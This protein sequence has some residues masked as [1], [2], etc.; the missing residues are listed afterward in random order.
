MTSLIAADDSK[1][2]GILTVAG[3][4][5]FCPVIPWLKILTDILK[6]QIK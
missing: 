6:R 1:T 5:I 2:R 3:H 4:M